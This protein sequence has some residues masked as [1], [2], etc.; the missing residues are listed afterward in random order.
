MTERHVEEFT[1]QNAW[2]ELLATFISEEDIEKVEWS[3]GA[4]IAGGPFKTLVVEGPPMS[5]KSTILILAEHI[6]KANCHRD[7]LRIGIHHE[8]IPKFLGEASF[9]FVAT[10]EP[11]DGCE[12]TYNPVITIRTTGELASPNRI[13]FLAGMVSSNPGPVARQCLTKYNELGSAHY[14]NTQENDQ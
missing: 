3:I 14:D 12:E 1:V 5:G 10:L 6:L 11:L 7:S 2:E 8:G 13:H 4:V 9:K